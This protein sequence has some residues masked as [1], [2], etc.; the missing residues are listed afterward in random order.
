MAAGNDLSGEGATNKRIVRN[1]L[2]GQKALVTGGSSGIGRGMA[3]AA[4]GAE[5]VVKSHS[6]VEHASKV[7]GE[8]Q[9]A[10]GRAYAHRAA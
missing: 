8:I 9:R 10:G 3:L 5:V 6:G 4:A 2:A 1:A 7:A